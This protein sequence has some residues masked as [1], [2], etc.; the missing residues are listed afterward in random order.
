MAPDFG[1]ESRA[2][3]YR[4]D[5]DAYCERRLDLYQGALYQLRALVLD[6][7][8]GEVQDDML[9]TLDLVERAACDP[10]IP[11]TRLPVREVKMV[12]DTTGKFG[13]MSEGFFRRKVANRVAKDWN[14]LHERTVK[15]IE[16]YSAPD[17]P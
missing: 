11:D 9:A 1:R 13:G 16:K 12:L 3:V 10:A 15:A 4:L 14:I 6:R 5:P 2:A 17:A 7:W 8:D